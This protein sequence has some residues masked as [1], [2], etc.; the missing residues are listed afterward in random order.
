MTTAQQLIEAAYARSTSNDPGKLAT[1]NELL[2]RLGRTYQSLFALASRQRPDEFATRQA[3]TLGGSNASVALTPDTI[4]IRRIQNAQGAK[5]HLIPATEIDRLWHVAP[6]VYRVGLSVIS[7]GLGGDPI[8]G[9]ALTAWL[10]LP[11]VTIAALSTTLDLTYPTRHVEILS[12]DLALYLDAKDSD[13][14]PEQFKKLAADQ[15]Y[16]L[17]L[18]AQ[19]FDLDASALEFVHAPTSRVPA[20]AK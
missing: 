1:D 19:D 10:L 8:A 7:R 5:V 2:G 16:R 17:G 11:G 18:F 14:D 4:E 3:L 9:D 15:G 20:S 12:N 6:C 13:R